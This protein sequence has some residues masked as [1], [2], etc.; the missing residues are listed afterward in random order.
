MDI[1]FL[2]IPS[3]ICSLLY[4]HS[5]GQTSD[6]GIIKR[7]DRLQ[8]APTVVLFTNSLS[9]NNKGGHLQGIQRLFYDEKEYLILSGSSDLFSY[10]TIVKNGEKGIV[11]SVNKCQV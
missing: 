8:N 3:F 2:L 1:K 5:N 6:R 11:I 10:Y 7:L 4:F 9:V